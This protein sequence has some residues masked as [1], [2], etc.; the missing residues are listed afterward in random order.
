MLA[1]HLA[2]SRSDRAE[3]APRSCRFRAEREA[4]WRELESILDTVESD[5]LRQ[6]TEAQLLRLPV[7][8]RAAVSS[9][10]VARAISLDK[11]LLAYLESLTAR[12]YCFVYGSHHS[13]L[14]ALRE[15][16]NVGFPQLVRGLRWWVLVAFLLL[17]AG[18]LIGH[19]LTLAAPERYWSLVPEEL[20]AGRSPLSTRGELLEIL[21]DQGAGRLDLLSAFASFLFTHNARIGMSCFAS[22]LA[23]G[24]PVALLLLGNGM[25][26][27]AL[28]AVHVRQGLG[29]EMW[30]WILPHG[31]TELLAVCLCAAA[32]FRVG[33]ALLFPGRSGRI[34][35]L[36][37]H[38]R[39]AGAVVVGS[40]GLFLLAALLE[41]FFRQAVQDTT[42]RLAVA[43]LTAGV[44]AAY[45]SLAGREDEPKAC[46]RGR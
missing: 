6:L 35:S 45:F 4:S 13:V 38:G 22:G 9:L 37:H 41:A 3:S 29:L 12:A 14:T 46:V 7:L 30:A 36:A 33:A 28:G 26:L 18:V 23:A 40:V 44:W 42:I 5:G 8:Y 27:G 34:A 31:V 32:G 39:Q 17:V 2:T 11:N 43:M 25:T 1:R 20:A 15:F 16:V 10:S 21:H 24:V 19:Q